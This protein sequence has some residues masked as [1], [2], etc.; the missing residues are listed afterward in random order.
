MKA[1]RKTVA[2]RIKPCLY[3]TILSRD[4]DFNYTYLSSTHRRATQLPRD[5]YTASCSSQRNCAGIIYQGKLNP[6]LPT[7]DTEGDPESWPV[8]CSPVEIQSFE[9]LLFLEE[10]SLTQDEAFLKHQRESRSDANAYNVEPPSH[11]AHEA[12]LWRFSCQ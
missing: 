4:I 6:T 1:D 7:S 10:L 12:V 5:L 8:L 9:S 2:F 3:A 11:H